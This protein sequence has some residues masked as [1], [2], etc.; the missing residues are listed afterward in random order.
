MPIDQ[1]HI[2]H[3]SAWKHF[4]A[5]KRD[6]VCQR[7]IGSK[8]KLLSSLAAGIEGPRD[9]CSAERSIG[10][11]SPIFTGKGNSLRNA[12]INDQNADFR[13]PVNVRFPRTKIAAFNCII[14]ETKNA[15]SI[16]L[17]IFRRINAALGGDAMRPAW[18]VLEA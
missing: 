7:L 15:V 4:D 6:L 9:L 12:L 2:E 8:K 17:I 18:R 1:N 10:Q 5:A 13:Q 16:V 14:K 11:K 3:F